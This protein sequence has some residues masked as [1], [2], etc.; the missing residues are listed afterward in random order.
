MSLADVITKAANTAFSIAEA[1]EQTVGLSLYA[2][3][4]AGAWIPGTDAFSAGTPTTPVAVIAVKYESEIDVEGAVTKTNAYLIRASEI[5]N[6]T[7][8]KAWK[9]FETGDTVERPIFAISIPHEA[10]VILHVSK[11]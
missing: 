3:N 11:G 5:T 4:T 7:P 1:G 2:P 9:L 10:I 8:T 6:G